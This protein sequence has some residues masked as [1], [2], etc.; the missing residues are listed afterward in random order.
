MPMI[1]I[2]Y[3]YDQNLD[4]LINRLERGCFLSIGWFASNYMKLNTEKY[5]LLISE[6]EKIRNYVEED[7]I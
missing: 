6:N 3:S 4:Q 2:H 7:K 5:Q 1:Q